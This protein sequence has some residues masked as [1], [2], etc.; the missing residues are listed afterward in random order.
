[1]PVLRKLFGVILVALAAAP[2][3]A[4]DFE[5]GWKWL[6]AATEIE[7]QGVFWN[8]RLGDGKDRW[9][10]GGLTQSWIFPEHIFSGGD[11]FAAHAS[12]LEVNLRG[13]VMTPDDT[14]FRG[15]NPKDRP[16]AQYAAV[17][18]YL[19]SI[20]RPGEIAPDLGLQTEDRIGV[21]IGWQG[22]PLP[23]FDI[24]SALHDFAGT[25]GDRGNP[26]NTID[27]EFLA[28]LEARRTWRF[29]GDEAGR[30]LE[31][32]PFVQTSLGMRENSL[33]T[34]ADVFIGSVL[35]GRIWGSDLAT[36]AV[37]AG[38]S[39]RRDGFNWTLFVGGDVGF[40]ASDAFVDGSFAGDGPR[41]ERRDIAAR[42]RAGILLE[43]DNLAIGFSLN[44]L[45]KEFQ[46]QSN[47]QTIGAI[48]LKYRL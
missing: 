33:R 47:G 41:V 15:A 23:L 44:R 30:D 16:Y 21:E 32:A 40:I 35:E 4:G 13:L 6:A 26:S 29:H 31:L 18:V 22:D 19:R 42:A 20:A 38:D 17:G 36:G 45:G 24:Q 46:G 11:W 43:Y 28:N 12:A 37:V 8:D 25:A 48:Q 5:Q 2:G 7:T 9:K 10:S 14:A 1:M 34:G 39:V 27:G 3:R